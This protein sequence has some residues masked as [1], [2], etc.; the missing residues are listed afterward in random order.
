MDEATLRRE[1]SE[2]AFG[3]VMEGE[4]SED[5]LGDQFAPAAIPERFR[6]YERLVN[7]HV[8][9][10]KEVAALARHLDEHLRNIKTET[11]RQRHRS[12]DMIDG[13]I[14]WP[15]TYQE[16]NNRAPN[17]RT[18]FV[19]ER[20]TTAYDIPENV[21]LKK[22]LSLLYE[23]VTE[24]GQLQYDWVTARWPEGDESTIEEFKRLYDRNVHLNR[25]TTPEPPKPTDRMIQA[26][27]S[28]RTAFYRTAAQK[29]EWRNEL[30]EGRVNA[31][32]SLFDSGI[33]EPSADRLFELFVVFELLKALESATAATSRIRPIEGGSEAL[34]QIG[35]PP[36]YV[37]QES[38]AADR[39]LRFPSMPVPESET[40]ES[41]AY[42]SAQTSDEWLRRSQAVS[43]W[44]EETKA[45]LWGTDS[46]SY[47][48][49]PDAILI[50]PHGDK[51]TATEIDI[52]IVEVKN[53]T[54][55]KT[56]NQ[57]ISQL[58]RYLAYATITAQSSPKFLFPQSSSESLFVNSSRGL[59]VV[60]DLEQEANTQA[61][62]TPISIVQASNLRTR[63]PDL[64]SN[65]F[66]TGGS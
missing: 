28:S 35:D 55:K 8:A 52:L 16:R 43:Y 2:L 46:D 27:K 5:W 64:L 38:S 25:I 10:D 9:L 6:E 19:T 37:Y 30:L 49:R 29:L 65:V 7:L 3:Y 15:R 40:V 42:Q 66:A 41:Y 54:A 53:S 47:T 58:L 23:T 26:A 31:L 59:L 63:L 61:V 32:E 18:L 60:Q 33:I 45:D 1:V 36:V 4:L 62:Q 44:T 12:R 20:R 48:G 56:I 50:R 51:T 17:D 24:M 14:D 21:V 57:G 39:N 13:H 22:L 34:G 11:K